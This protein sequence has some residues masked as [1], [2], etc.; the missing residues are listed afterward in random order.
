[1]KF[2][3]A[4]A[5]FMIWPAVSQAQFACT[6]SGAASEDACLAQT[7]DSGDSCV[8]CSLTQFGFCVNEQQAEA[9]EQALP[10]VQCDRKPTPND[11]DQAPATDDVQPTTDDTTPNDDQLPDNYWQCLEQKDAE[12]CAAQEGCKWCKTKAGFGLCMTGPTADSAADSDW[13]DCGKTDFEGELTEDYLGYDDDLEFDD[14]DE[15][16]DP[17]DALEVEA[18]DPYD[19]SCAMA[20]VQDPT[21]EG[22]KG[23]VDQDGNPCEWCDVSGMINICLTVEQAQMA[24]ALGITCEEFQAK[25][26]L[27]GN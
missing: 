19:T 20:Y 17:Y 26:L 1:M 3:S 24:S 8:W 6:F 18:E 13:F 5:L 23:A 4:L 25:S 14:E 16:E 2:P 10:G 9:M 11:D 27:R 22:C 7:D 15:S 12:T 21:E